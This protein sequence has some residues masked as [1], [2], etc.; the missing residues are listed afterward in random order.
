ML[1]RLTAAIGT[2]M[3]PS[4]EEAQQPV[5]RGALAGTRALVEATRPKQWIKNLLLLLAFFFS[6]NQ[7]WD[8]QDPSQGLKL[9]GQAT[10]GFLVFCALSGAVYLINDVADVERDRR[11][12]QKRLRP[13]ASGRLSSGAALGAG[14]LLTAAGLA[15]A[16]ALDWEFATVALAYVVLTLAYTY[17]LKRLVLVDVL[18]LSGGF[19][20]R[21][22]AG[23]VVI[24]VP[25]SPWL[26][27]C[28]GMGAL[29]ISFGKRR[30]ELALASPGDTDAR[31]ALE[32]YS[33]PV[34]DQLIA[35]VAAATLMAYSLYTFT[36][37]NLPSNHTM[38]LTVPFVAY[39]L[40]RYL[41]LLHVRNLGESPEEVLFGDTPLRI[42]VLLWLAAASGVL[43]VF[44]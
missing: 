14:V 11:H 28:T 22:V 43:L 30:N 8:F 1:A 44:R 18:A 35:L 29:F 9:L 24:D 16:A 12:P 7:S 20:L 32:G 19:V 6:L 10:A 38:M 5:R 25:I 39:G 17:V 34:L 23:A 4:M 37:E 36:A 15:L 33:L 31:E 26:Y 40:F 42:A 21:A 3:M 13:V 2:S 41:H 27:I